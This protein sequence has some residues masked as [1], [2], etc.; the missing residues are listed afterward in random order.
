MKRPHSIWIKYLF[1]QTHS[2]MFVDAQVSFP[3]LYFTTTH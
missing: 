3:E 1:V 2:A